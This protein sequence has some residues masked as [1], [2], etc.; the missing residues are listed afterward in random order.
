MK[1]LHERIEW[2]EMLRGYIESAYAVCNDS[3]VNTVIIK[4]CSNLKRLINCKSYSY[5]DPTAVGRKLRTGEFT[6][7]IPKSQKSECDYLGAILA[8]YMNG[9]ETN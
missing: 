7:K 9:Q 5:N 1:Y 2:C 6:D 3:D 4:T 8:K